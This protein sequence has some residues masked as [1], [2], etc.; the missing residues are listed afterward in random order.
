MQ[1]RFNSTT[2]TT[3]TT[4][5]TYTVKKAVKVPTDVK[6]S[7]L[8]SESF[9]QS[10]LNDIYYLSSNMANK[11]TQQQEADA[12]KIVNII[13]GVMKRTNAT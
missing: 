8:A 10:E 13:N 5:Q 7:R 9:D 4:S 11:N 2:T 3:T 1:N 12:E 6:T